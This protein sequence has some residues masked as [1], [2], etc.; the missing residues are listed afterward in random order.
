M[1]IKRIAALLLVVVMVFSFTACKEKP[2]NNV[3]NMPVI[4]GTVYSC[5]DRVVEER[6][7]KDSFLKKDKDGEVLIQATTDTLD[8]TFGFNAEQANDFIV[9]CDSW[10]AYSLNVKINNNTAVSQTFSEFTSNALP[11]G[12]WLGK[13]SLNGTMSIVANSTDVEFPAVLIID[14]RKVNVADMCTVLDTIAI[15]IKYFATPDDGDDEAPESEYKRLSVTNNLEL[16]DINLEPEKQLS[17]KRTTIEDGS[18]FLEIYKENPAAFSSEAKLFGLD[19]ATVS[20]VLAANSGWE[21]YTLNIEIQNKTADELNVLKI[22]ADNNGSNGVWISGVSQY[23][24][25]GMPAN[26]TDVLPVSVL[27]DTSALGGKSAQEAIAELNIQLGYAA[28]ELI[29]EDGEDEFSPENALPLK[30]INVQ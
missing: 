11:D 17:A 2:A 8:Y 5:F 29:Y 10:K 30:Y 16:S 3:N 22:I 27:V 24:E 4:E 26:K 18:S 14:T 28:G 6:A 15:E 23:G 9:S 7:P 19:E 13:E 20:E 21:W 1:K 12:M 25:Y